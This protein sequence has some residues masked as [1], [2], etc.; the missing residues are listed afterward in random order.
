MFTQFCAI[1]LFLWTPVCERT[2]ALVLQ[3][4]ERNKLK[5]KLHVSCGNY[6]DTATGL[7]SNTKNK[8]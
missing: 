7:K 6:N 4:Y 1:L 3:L 5:L 8:D 2:L